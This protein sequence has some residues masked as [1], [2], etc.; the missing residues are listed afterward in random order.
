MSFEQKFGEQP[1]IKKE[2]NMETEGEKI[3]LRTAD[4]ME[5]WHDLKSEGDKIE[6]PELEKIEERRVMEKEKLCGPD[7]NREEI[8]ANPE[9]QKEHVEFLKNWD[10]LDEKEKINRL[11]RVWGQLGAMRVTDKEDRKSLA[12]YIEDVGNAAQDYSVFSK[13]KEFKPLGEVEDKEWADLVKRIKNDGGLDSFGK[14]D[15]IRLEKLEKM[16]QIEQDVVLGPDFG[17]FGLLMSP[18]AR[19]N[20]LNFIDNWDQLNSEEKEERLSRASVIKER[21]NIASG[22]E[23]KKTFFDDLVIAK[24][25]ERLSSR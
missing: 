4:E 16:G 23:P 5:R 17:Y 8:L 1:E 14:E 25:R 3:Q 22:G 2:E 15:M 10:G 11:D 12:K 13:S 24:K 20:H 21:F 6:S 19:K 7:L 18:D 9:K